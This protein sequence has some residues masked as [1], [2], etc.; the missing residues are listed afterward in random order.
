MERKN[1]NGVFLFWA[2]ETKTTEMYSN[3]GDKNF[4]ES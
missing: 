4:K 2:S 3:L 1:D